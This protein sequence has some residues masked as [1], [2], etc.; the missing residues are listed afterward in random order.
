MVANID[1]APSVYEA[2]GAG[3]PYAVDGDSLLSRG[4]REYLLTERLVGGHWSRFAGIVT[5]RLHYFE[6]LTADGRARTR[7]LYNL[8][9]DPYELENMGKVGPSAV[10]GEI[11]EL[12][13]LLRE[14]RSCAGTS[15]P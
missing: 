9:Q 15:C 13:R 12:H 1:I 11:E 7:E 14:A 5:R 6:N 8:R 3:R 4:A 2:V 10:E